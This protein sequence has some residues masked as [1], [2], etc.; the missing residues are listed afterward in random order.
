M[1]EDRGQVG[2]DYGKSPNA[3]EA[4][5]LKDAM[6]AIKNGQPIG[7]GIG[8]M[9]VGEMMLGTTKEPAAFETVWSKTTLQFLLSWNL[10]IQMDYLWLQ[11]FHQPLVL[12]NLQS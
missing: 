8:P 9:I 2:N 12:T 11:F 6:P 4:V 1:S 5:A 7:D 10:I 3:E